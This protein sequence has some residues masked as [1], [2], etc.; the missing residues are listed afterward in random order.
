MMNVRKKAH[1]PV[2]MP[3]ADQWAQVKPEAKCACDKKWIDE[4]VHLYECK[5]L[6]SWESR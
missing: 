2:D 3:E 4:E 6:G 1:A 5:A